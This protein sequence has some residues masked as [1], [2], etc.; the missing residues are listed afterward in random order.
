[1]SWPRI[2]KALKTWGT[3]RDW[4]TV[5]KLLEIAEA[6]EA[7]RQFSGNSDLPI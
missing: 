6:L 1:M 2:E 4:N 3:G 5:T 7:A